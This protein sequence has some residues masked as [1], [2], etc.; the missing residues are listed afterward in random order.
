MLMVEL[1]TNESL[2]AASPSDIIQAPHLCNDYHAPAKSNTIGSSGLQHNHRKS[3]EKSCKEDSEPCAA[4][5]N[6]IRLTLNIG[7]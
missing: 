3:I 4:G 2:K 6:E 5:D 7:L 1:R